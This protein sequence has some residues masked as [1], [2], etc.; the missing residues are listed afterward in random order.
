ML[1]TAFKTCSSTNMQHKNVTHDARCSVACTRCGL[2][3]AV[4]TCSNGNK[5]VKSI[6]KAMQL[7]VWHLN[8]GFLG[9][10]DRTAMSSLW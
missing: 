4:K 10:S 9:I 2:L 5:H 7:A 6:M 8:E 1:F 3:V